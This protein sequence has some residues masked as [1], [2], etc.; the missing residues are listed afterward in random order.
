VAEVLIAL[1]AR[2]SIKASQQKLHRRC[3]SRHKTIS[4]FGEFR[5]FLFSIFS[6]SAGRGGRTF[7]SFEI[8]MKLTI[9]QLDFPCFFRTFGGGDNFFV[10]RWPRVCVPAV[11]N[12][13]RPTVKECK[14][15]E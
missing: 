13:G 15:P 6:C 9:F 12:S 4:S 11:V 7:W 1:A 10:D 3:H 5:R 8:F 14:W 2:Q